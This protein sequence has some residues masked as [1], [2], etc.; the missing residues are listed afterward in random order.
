MPVT[1][2]P[3][4]PFLRAPTKTLAFTGAANLGQAATAS[5][6]WTITGRVLLIYGTTFC[7]ETL[8]STVNLGVLRLGVASSTNGFLTQTT[9]GAGTIS[10]NAW[11]GDQQVTPGMSTDWVMNANGGGAWGGPIV[12]SQ[13]IIL[14]ADTQDITDG[15][16]VFDCYYM[17]LTAG[18]SLA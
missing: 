9:I 6:I 1:S 11:W 16:L 3:D 10:V 4:Y 12:I 2:R 18:G 7:T 5:T 13:N 15:T 8:V 17:P 14:S